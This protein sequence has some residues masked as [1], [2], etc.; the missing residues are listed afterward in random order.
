MADSTYIKDNL[1]GSVP[2]EIASTVIKN[3]VTE[4]VVLKVCNHT[5]MTSDTK[6]IPMLKDNGKAY[7]VEEGEE[8]NT[9]I[10][11]WEYPELKAKKLAVIVPC[12]KEKLNDS[13]LN[14]MDELKQGIA[15]AFIRA[16]DGA[17][18]FGTDS[19]F[20]TNI[21]ET[22]LNTVNRA[23]GKG[24]DISISEAMTKIEEKD[25]I[26]NAIIAPLSEK[27]EIRLLRDSNGNA[28]VVPGGISG[29]N[30]YETP[31]HYP[32]SKVFNNEK[33]ELLVGD[34][35][36]AMIGTREGITYEV[37]KEATVNGLNLAVRDMIAIKCT[38]RVGFKVLKPD[39]FSV[40]KRAEVFK[41]NLDEEAGAHHIDEA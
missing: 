31:I 36:R 40:L 2:T 29:S 34:F 16:L 30:I 41:L 39:A 10:H 26:P 6:K 12:T 21:C 38:M 11:D 22:A 1:S 17:V 18:L 7:W 14:V 4:S 24:L 19:P 32:A 23:E 35:T 28:L 27:G 3:I 9:A 8:I 25:F 13:V 20:D 33:A 15:D 37:L 5:D